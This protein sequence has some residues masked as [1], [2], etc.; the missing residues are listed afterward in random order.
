MESSSFVKLQNHATGLY[1]HA[2][3]KS[4]FTH[5]LGNGARLVKID[6]EPGVCKLRNPCGEYYLQVDES[7]DIFVDTKTSGAYDQWEISDLG[8]GKY[9][10]LNGSL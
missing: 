10:L 2:D 4:V 5:S 8:N 7:G 3:K 1:L 6:L 9:T